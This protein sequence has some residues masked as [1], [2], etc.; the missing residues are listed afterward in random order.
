VGTTFNVKDLLLLVGESESRTTPSQEGE[1]NDDNPSI[2]SSPPPYEITSDI[3]GPI[4]RSRAKQWEKEMHSQVNA[5]LVLNNQI[6]LNEP[7]LLSTF[8]NILR[9][10]GVHERA[11][12][13]D[14]ICPP[15]IWTK[16]LGHA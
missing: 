2:H 5:N 4:A 8:F 7:M 14:G 15:N 12:D 1:A 6:I 11:W 16:E 3:V 9:N 10:D 13:D